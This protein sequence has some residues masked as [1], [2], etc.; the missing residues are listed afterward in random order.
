[1][2]VAESSR[3]RGELE[4]SAFRWQAATV[5]WEAR[6]HSPTPTP[7]CATVTWLAMPKG[8]PDEHFGA[9]KLLVQIVSMLKSDQANRLGAWCPG[10]PAL[11]EAGHR[12][13]HEKEAVA[14]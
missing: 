13:A 8:L 10:T 4:L 12:G 7:G 2:V 1:M 9:D 5:S 11:L 6:L 3:T 14:K